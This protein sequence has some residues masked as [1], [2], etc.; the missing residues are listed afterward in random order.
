M[1]TFIGTPQNPLQVKSLQTPASGLSA[2]DAFDGQNGNPS[3]TGGVFLI[4]PADPDPG[5]LLEV[6]VFARL[7]ST[8][9]HSKR[10]DIRIWGLRLFGSET[11]K[12]IGSHLAD[13][14]PRVADKT[15]TGMMYGDDP[16]NVCDDIEVV[17][18]TT[19]TPPGIRIIGNT[20]KSNA[21][22][23]IDPMGCKK[24]VVQMAKGEYSS[25]SDLT[26]GVCWRPM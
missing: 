21:G 6:L 26:V 19:S 20:T 16:T 8:S 10:L 14:K 1:A 9:N 17:E 3:E 25:T 18:D 23:L 11:S 4:D 12:Y 15:I 2:R 13:V 22:I 7:A 5:N 24:L